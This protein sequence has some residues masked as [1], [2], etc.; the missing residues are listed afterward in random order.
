MTKKEEIIRSL[1]RMENMLKNIAP[2]KRMHL[3]QEHEYLETEIKDLK[4][5]IE[6]YFKNK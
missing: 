2:G 3:R 4:N 5:R 6:S 1:N